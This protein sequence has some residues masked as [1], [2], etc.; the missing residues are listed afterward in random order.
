VPIW[1]VA[2]LILLAA[3]GG[4]I[5]LARFLSA[6]LIVTGTILAIVYLMMIWIDAFGQGMSDENAVTGRWLME[7]FGCEKQRCEQLA[8]P[9]TLALKL[10]VLLLSVPLILL[11]WGFDWKDIADWSRELFVGFRIGN[12]QI[13]VAAIL[14]S[15]LV[16]A[17]GY[18]AAR[19]F[20]GWLDRQVLQPA[21]VS[22]SVRHSIRTAV[23]YMGVIVAAMFAISY[24][25]LDLSNIALVA[26]AL[27]VGIGLGLQ[28]VV[29]NFVSGMILLVE[30]PIKV[31]DQVVVG[32]EEGIVR[33]ISVRS[34]EIET[35]DRA[36]VLV[37]NSAFISEKVK[38][39]TLHNYSARIVIPVSVHYSNDARRVREILLEVA[40]ANSQV[41]TAPEPSVALDEFAASA[42]V[43]KLYV[44]VYDLTKGGSVRTDL[45]LA[46]LEAFQKEDVGMPNG[47]KETAP[48]ETPTPKPATEAAAAVAEIRERR[49]RRI[50]ARNANANGN[51]HGRHSSRN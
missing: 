43:F 48:P 50:H 1:A 13:S 30:R 23:G 45:R 6:Q 18:A 51:G 2:I 44:F 3:V 24:A 32:G 7:T 10:A 29:N 41:M 39:W 49:R 14:A 37:P 40:R 12:T 26:G 19:L 42:M 38:N 20:Q 11:Q 9:A 8:L 46:I 34:T 15:L 31:G 28:G 33:R 25:G 22:G 36:N 5:S 17:L 35:F 16:F 4:Y 47:E 27:S 21:G